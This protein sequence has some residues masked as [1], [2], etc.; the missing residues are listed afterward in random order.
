M[1]V[2]DESG[3]V[4]GVFSERDLIY[5]LGL[6]ANN[7]MDKEVSTQMIKDPQ[8]VR[9]GTSLGRAIFFMA[10]EGYRH[11]PVVGIDGRVESVLSVRDFLNYI[12][13][14]FAHKLIKK[15]DCAAQESALGR[16]LCMSIKDIYA[17]DTV[18]LAADQNAADFVTTMAQN[19]CG[20]AVVVDADRRVKGIVTERDY[21]I[22]VIGQCDDYKS[23]LI[24]DFMTASPK[25]LLEGSTV[26]LA[27]NSMAEGG[28][29]HLPIVDDDERLIGMLSVRDLSNAVADAIVQDLTSG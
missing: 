23:K 17:K 22:K 12:H 21:L 13:T 1:F 19:R 15:S 29:R 14:A 4:A 26:A 18:T 9:T 7:L 11:V 3:P 2:Q 8:C 25:T 28:F 20:S 5:Q 24:E 6:Y 10:K 27:F 16:L